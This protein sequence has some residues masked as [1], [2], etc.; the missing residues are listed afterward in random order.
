MKKITNGEWIADLGAMT[1]WNINSRIVI[2]FEKKRGVISG[3]LKNIPIRLF[4][5]WAMEP[6]V[7]R[8]IQKAVME[9]E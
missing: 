8:M 4:V 6:H 3:K 2:C 5:Q 9:A 1:C 7:E